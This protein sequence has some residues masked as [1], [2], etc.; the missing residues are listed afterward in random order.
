MAAPTRVKVRN[1]T[2]VAYEVN[3]KVQLAVDVEPGDQLQYTGATSRG[4][5]VMTKLPIDALEADGIALRKG[6]AG[7]RGF[8]VGL[9]GEM[10]GFSGLVPG[11]PYFPS[12]AIAGGLDSTVVVD[13]TI[14]VKAVKT[15][16]IR[17][18]YV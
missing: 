1:V 8:D 14:R 7:E 2:V 17:F 12:G 13:A 15:T 11:T 18:C 16:R 9:H 6:Y 3:D 4:Q 10:D 5:S